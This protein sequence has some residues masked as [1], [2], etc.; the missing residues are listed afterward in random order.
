M[1][2]LLALLSLLATVH[3]TSAVN[4]GGTLSLTLTCGA[5]A[6]CSGT[7]ELPQIDPGNPVA[8]SVGAGKAKTLQI[9]L[10]GP[11]KATVAKLKSL[12]VKLTVDGA[13]TTET[14][15][16]AQRV[17]SS[18]GGSPSGAGSSA[19]PRDGP[20]ISA[21]KATRYQVVHDRRGDNRSPGF[22]YP[23]NFDLVSA[24]A[25]RVGNNVVFSV[26]SVQAITMHDSSGN[27]VAPCVEIPYT[28][29]PGPI[30]PVQLYPS[31]NIA[32]VTGYMHD[33]PTIRTTIHGATISWT[34]PRKYLFAGG[35]L[36]RATAGCNPKYPADVAP[37]KG[38][39]TFRWA[40]V[41]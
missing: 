25:K 8:F 22:D 14:V 3:P 1:I 9:E 11:C 4:D 24:S 32:G 10:C 40:K 26:T 12:Q 38:F 27:P 6:A 21:G 37:N 35:F 28:V 18:P 7:Y 2:R 17:G 30:T 41:K 23:M 5:D 19:G 34:V 31:G 20:K 16:L 29:K 13:S 39:E 36:W 15:A 33:W